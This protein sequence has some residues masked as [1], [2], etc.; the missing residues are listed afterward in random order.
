MSA[1]SQY[2]IDGFSRSWQQDGADDEERAICAWYRDLL[3]PYCPETVSRTLDVGCGAGRI[4]SVLAGL[5]H[6]A[7]HVAI[8]GSDAAVTRTA[9]RMRAEAIAGAARCVDIT[10]GRFS[11][12]LLEEFGRFDFV[13][14]FFVLHHYAPETI[15]GILAE[16]RDLCADEGVI[17]LV[18]CHDPADSRAAVTE[19]TCAALAELAGVPP[20]TLLTPEALEACCRAAGF[21]AD[22]IRFDV[23]SGQ[24]FTDAERARHAATLAQLRARLARLTDRVGPSTAPPVRELEALIETMSAQSI[25]GPIRHPPAIAV[26][27]VPDAHARRSS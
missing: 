13:T 4:T 15:V 1:T 6:G 11:R 14:C 9:A 2:W 21:G 26:L 18:E 10:G 19:R 20:D 23:R 22:D 16:L 7:F 3:T 5:C 8:D 17:V 25:C 27:R 24:P 12:A